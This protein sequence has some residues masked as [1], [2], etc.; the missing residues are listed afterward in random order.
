MIIYFR[1]RDVWKGKFPYRPA[2]GWCRNSVLFQEL[3]CPVR[4]YVPAR[5]VMGRVADVIC[6]RVYFVL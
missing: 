1:F 3:L 4:S 5:D 2:D 6:S